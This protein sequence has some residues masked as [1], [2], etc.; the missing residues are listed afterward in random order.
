MRL[1]RKSTHG[2]DLQLAPTF[3]ARLAY[4]ITGQL[5]LAISPADALESK[6]QWSQDAT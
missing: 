2:N 6:S 5:I 3:A 4:R 1:N